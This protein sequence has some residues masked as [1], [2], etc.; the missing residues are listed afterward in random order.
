M[1]G[2][3][4]QKLKEE[5]EVNATKWKKNERLMVNTQFFFGLSLILLLMGTL[6]LGCFLKLDPNKVIIVLLIES[7]TLVSLFIG[8]VYFLQKRQMEL[9]RKNCNYFKELMNYIDEEKYIRLNEW[10]FLFSRTVEKDLMMYFPQILIKSTRKINIDQAEI[11][12]VEFDQK[13]L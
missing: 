4:I 5:M 1:N 11:L 3:Q 6:G 7:T 12:Y 9:S 10:K 2:A 8:R 13:L